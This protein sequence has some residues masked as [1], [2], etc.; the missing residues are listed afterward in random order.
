MPWD[1]F[2]DLQIMHLDGFMPDLSDKG[3]KEQFIA[4]MNDRI[5][6]IKEKETERGGFDKLPRETIEVLEKILEEA[7]H[8]KAK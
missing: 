7:S 1:N 4:R 5:K 8:P 3:Y 6:F 2:S